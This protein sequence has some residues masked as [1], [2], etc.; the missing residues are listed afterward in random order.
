MVGYKTR[1]WLEASNL[2]YT[3]K[4]SLAGAYS[5]SHGIPTYDHH[6]AKSRGFDRL[7]DW[8]EQFYNMDDPRA[9]HTLPDAPAG[10]I[11]MVQ[12]VQTVAYTGLQS[13]AGPSVNSFNTPNAW[14]FNYPRPFSTAGNQRLVTQY[15][16]V[17]ANG[18]GEQLNNVT[19]Y[20]SSQGCTV[21]LYDQLVQSSRV[22][23]YRIRV[24][25]ISRPDATEGCLY[26]AR[27]D[28]HT[29]NVTNGVPTFANLFGT[30]NPR[31][32]GAGVVN[33]YA[34]NERYSTGVMTMSTL[35]QKGEVEFFFGPDCEEDLVFDQ[36]RKP[37]ATYGL[38][39]PDF[40]T[41]N[42]E[43]PVFLIFSD[44]STLENKIQ[45]EIEAMYEV[46]PLFVSGNGVGFQANAQN[47]ATSSANDI[48]MK[49]DPD[50]HISF[51]R[52]HEAQHRA[53]GVPGQCKSSSPKSASNA[54][55]QAAHDVVNQYHLEAMAIAAAAQKAYQS[56]AGNS[57]SLLGKAQGV[58]AGI[59]A[60]A[61]KA[62]LDF[63]GGAGAKGYNFGPVKMKKGIT[64][65]RISP[66][67]PKKARV[68]PARVK[69]IVVYD[70][71]RRTNVK[72]NWKTS[73][74][75]RVG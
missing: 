12:G 52:A 60:G 74:K 67:R 34:A 31:V 69:S 59:A 4:S 19:Y 61:A 20:S 45:I 36:Y 37:L 29:Y 16:P 2:R 23:G 35:C 38:E 43:R 68:D 27:L 48:K 66:Y 73:K 40:G 70:P 72:A 17:L 64:V 32:G 58:A 3:A 30:N 24:R 55:K 7:H 26:F 57:P 50:V 44:S 18:Q 65:K 53:A 14:L 9:R 62:V 33:D 51:H 63:T 6:A 46:V 39:Y 56:A 22:T 41:A 71:R 47:A 25:V 42:Q 28:R 75:R 54:H 10:A 1:R 11:T 15:R 49:I 5:T 21:D 13:G 8:V